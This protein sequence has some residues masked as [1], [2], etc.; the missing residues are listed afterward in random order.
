MTRGFLKTLRFFHLINKKAYKKRM[1]K[2]AP[3]YRAIAKSPLFDAKW[4][5]EHNP[6]V[7]AAKADPVEHYLTI[8]WK[9]DRPTTPYFDGKA[10][11][12]MYPDVAKANMNPLAHWLLHGQFEDRYADIHSPEKRF[13]PFLSVKTAIRNI[14]TYPIKVAEDCF[15]LKNE[16]KTLEQ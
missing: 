11:L 7:A 3:E 9:E 15:R 5:L 16:I 6:D 4:Y 1:K 12:Q 10:Y 13:A 8:G 14:V 2:Y